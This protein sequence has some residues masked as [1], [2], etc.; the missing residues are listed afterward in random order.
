[1]TAPTN[2]DTGE[3]P[4]AEPAAPWVQPTPPPHSH[5]VVN[6]GL[7]GL[8]VVIILGIFLGFAGGLASHALFPPAAGAK[9]ATGAPGAP[10]KDGKTGPTGATG[11]AAN[12]DLSKLGVCVNVTYGGDGVQYSWVQNVDVSTPTLTNGATQSCPTGTF[13]P[14]QAAPVAAPTQ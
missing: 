2:D 12:V 1:M 14:V 7:V 10:G 11:S 13:T 4:I 9:G 5:G 3:I 8:S 6:L